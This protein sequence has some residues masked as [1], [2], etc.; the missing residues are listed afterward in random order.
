MTHAGILLSK[1]SKKIQV[2]NEIQSRL[3]KYRD[4]SLSIST[5]FFQNTNL[6]LRT[7]WKARDTRRKRKKCINGIS[8]IKQSHTHT[9]TR[10]HTCW[11]FL[12]VDFPA[13]W[14]SFQQRNE[15]DD[16]A[17]NHSRRS[18]GMCKCKCVCVSEKQ[19]PSIFHSFEAICQVDY[20]KLRCAS[21]KWHFMRPCVRIKEEEEEEQQH[22]AIARVWEDSYD[23]RDECAVCALSWK[24]M[25]VG[26][27]ES[28]FEML[29]FFCTQCQ[30]K[31]I[32]LRH[33]RHH[34]LSIYWS[35]RLRRQE[36]AVLD[37]GTIF[38]LKCLRS[39]A[40]A[41]S[42]LN[43][44]HFDNCIKVDNQKK[45]LDVFHYSS[46]DKL[47]QVAA[48]IPVKAN[49][50]LISVH[51]CVYKLIV[52]IGAHV[53]AFDCTKMRHT[54]SWLLI[55]VRLAVQLADITYAPVLIFHLAAKAANQP[56]HRIRIKKKPCC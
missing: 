39:D 10:V 12:R 1:Y 29:L 27:K 8:T 50:I 38:D 44:D 35:R 14:V 20:L 19:V 23:W 40:V 5:P 41:T 33:C 15:S 28:I 18:K 26:Y 47:A 34:N 17:A 46:A 37:R 53:L 30:G 32:N 22:Y 11:H 16:N 43:Y 42:F 54:F 51:M 6:S 2:N 36:N 25:G 56:C 48:N 45:V 21:D 13:H 3:N 55:L 52:N 31:L 4:I 7:N 24:L 49:R 9:H